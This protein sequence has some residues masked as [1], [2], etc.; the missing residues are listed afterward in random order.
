MGRGTDAGHVEAGTQESDSTACSGR[1]QTRRGGPGR[2]AARLGSL[3]ASSAAR[4][5]ARRRGLALPS[6]CPPVGSGGGTAVPPMPRPQDPCQQ[7]RELHVPRERCPRPVTRGPGTVA[8]GH[9]LTPNPHEANQLRFGSPEATAK[10]KRW[11]PRGACRVPLPSSPGPP[12]SP[13]ATAVAQCTG[14]PLLLVTD[15]SQR[16]VRLRALKASYLYF[17]QSYWHSVQ[18]TGCSVNF[19]ELPATNFLFYSK[20]G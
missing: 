12:G 5:S 17:F 4:W 16:G 20:V 9:L 15:H 13:G 1:M 14:H 18:E 8:L 6:P 10:R 7:R 3:R 2:T 11:A 19:T